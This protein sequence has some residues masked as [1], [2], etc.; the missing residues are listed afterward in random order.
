MTNN[1]GQ[2]R[3]ARAMMI[4]VVRFYL[5][6][7]FFAED[8]VANGWLAFDFIGLMVNGLDFYDGATATEEDGTPPSFVEHAHGCEIRE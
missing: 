7:V 1:N 4:I 3:R 2:Q 8:E 6:R 5:G